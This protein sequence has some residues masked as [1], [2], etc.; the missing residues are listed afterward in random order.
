MT[1]ILNNKVRTWVTKLVI[2]FSMG[3][4]HR[5]ISQ[6]QDRLFGQRFFRWSECVL[7]FD[8]EEHCASA[9]FCFL[10]TCANIVFSHRS[11]LPSPGY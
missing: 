3:H 2:G 7:M 10:L 11:V 8:S 4:R 5:S 1:A 6:K 9:Y